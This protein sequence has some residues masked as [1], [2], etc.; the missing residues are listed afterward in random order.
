MK[1]SIIFIIYC[2][3]IISF[4]QKETKKI[5]EDFDGDGKTEELIIH[6]YLGEVN[7]AV[8]TYEDGAKQF[9]F[10]LS[11]NPNQYTLL[12]TIPICDE[13]TTSKY[14]TLLDNVEKYIFKEPT[15]KKPNSTFQWLIDVYGSK[16]T[17]QNHNYFESQSQ[18]SPII[19]S[20]KYIKP[21]SQKMIVTG[22]LA[23]EFNSKFNKN[24]SVKTSW[25]TFNATP[26][27]N[28]RQVSEYNINPDWPQLIDSV[29]GFKVYK[30]GHSVFMENDS[31]HQ[32][33]FVSDGLLYEN[34]QKL[35]WESIQQVGKYKDFF[36]V[37]THPYPAIENKLF[38]INPKTG[39]LFEFKKTAI[40]D[41]E[42]YFRYIESFEVMEDEL[43][44]FLKESPSALEVKEKSFPFI[45]L[46]ESL[47]NR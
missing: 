35:K 41:Y 15:S 9:T 36:L 44:L 42:N 45:A 24:D 29:N 22:Q 7:K 27:S 26:L 40:T 46:K 10:D 8:L 13:L 19:N 16:K 25:L 43:Y 47:E 23:Y 33:L 38:M 17:N 30:T 11:I 4:A 3:P 12:N 32:I 34:I 37:L 39:D 28:A 20:T 5:Q 6:K 14:K 2:I 21:S 18:F 31:S 1:A